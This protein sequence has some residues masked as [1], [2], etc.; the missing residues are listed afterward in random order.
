MCHDGFRK[1]SCT[2]PLLV[3]NGAPNGRNEFAT[4]PDDIVYVCQGNAWMD[5]RVMHLCIDKILKPHIDQAPPG[6]V[7]LLLLDPYHCHMMQSTVN[8]IEDLGVEVEHIPGGCTSLCQPVDVNV[9]KPF[10]SRMRRL[11]EEWMISTGL[12]HKGK[13][14]PT[15]K[16]IAEW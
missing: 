6:I 15:R 8:A 2:T 12:V 11:C 10:K 14:P 1:R 5:E 16:H 3:L 13:I 7:P 9:N 4:Y